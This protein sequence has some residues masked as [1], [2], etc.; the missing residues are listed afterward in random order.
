MMINLRARVEK[1]RELPS[2]YCLVQIRER[3]LNNIT[4][5]HG[6]LL[7][8]NFINI[9]CAYCMLTMVLCLKFQV[10]N[11]YISTSTLSISIPCPQEFI[12]TF[13]NNNCSIGTEM[14][15][16]EEEEK[17]NDNSPV[18]MLEEILVS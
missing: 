4:F 8:T 1:K 17:R 2:Y 16:C 9:Y 14:E 7:V 3:F 10:L 13:V 6:H 11:M 18:H 12:F 5:P 15:K